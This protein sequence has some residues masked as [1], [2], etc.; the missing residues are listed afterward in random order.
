MAIEQKKILKMNYFVVLIPVSLDALSST[1][2]FM[3]LTYLPTSIYKLLFS[4]NLILTAVYTRVFLKKT[5]T[6][7][8]IAGIS[9]LVVG[10]ILTG[11]S[12]T[13]VH[14]SQET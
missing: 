6:K 5:I 4:L 8:Q 13:V 2:Q 3:S 10:V 12:N 14:T 1:L 11:L 7:N 9:F